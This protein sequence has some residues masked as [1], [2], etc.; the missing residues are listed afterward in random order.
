MKR[1]QDILARRNA[2]RGLLLDEKRRVRRLIAAKLDEEEDF[3]ENVKRSFLMLDLFSENRPRFP[4]TMEGA[5]DLY[6]SLL[7]A[8]E[9]GPKDELSS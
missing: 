8:I 4:M 9:R 6:R 1:I 2:K 5:R 7:D 3:F